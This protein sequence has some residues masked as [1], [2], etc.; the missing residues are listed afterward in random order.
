MVVT[1]LCVH[2]NTAAAFIHHTDVA[3]SDVGPR[4]RALAQSLDRAK[5][6]LG[7]AKPQGPEQGAEARILVQLR[8]EAYQDH[9]GHHGSIHAGLLSHAAKGARGGAP[10]YDRLQTDRHYHTPNRRA[11]RVLQSLR[12]DG[13]SSA[14]SLSHLPLGLLSVRAARPAPRL[15]QALSQSRE[16]QAAFPVV[17]T[18]EHMR[19]S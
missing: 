15:L 3:P 12:A 8:A 9:D 4:G 14:Q 16:V 18:L 13:A 19:V 10:G 6:G 1:L 7:V 5:K 11:A 17:R 2:F